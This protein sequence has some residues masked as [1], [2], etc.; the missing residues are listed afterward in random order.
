[1]KLFA[2][3]PR[4]LVILVVSLLPAIATLLLTRF[5]LHANLTNFAPVYWNDQTWYWHQT[6]SFS[7]VGFAS[8]YYMVN[9]A[10]APLTFFKF[11]SAGPLFPV[12]FGTIGH[13]IGWG[14]LSGIGLNM[15][16]LAVALWLLVYLAE[17]DKTQILLTGLALLV[18]GPVLMFLPTNSQESFHQAGA[19]ILAGLFYRLWMG[20]MSR[21]LWWIGLIFLLFISL[22]RFSWV[23]LLPAYLLINNRYPS[24]RRGIFSLLIGGLL[25]LGI[26][27]LVSF[28]SSPGHNAIV[29][30]VGAF[31]SNPVSALQ[32]L[33]YVVMD[34][35]N[36][37]F[38]GAFDLQKL[39]VNTTQ[40]FQIAIIGISAL[41]MVFPATEMRAR[42]STKPLEM[43]FHIYNLVLIIG[44]SLV[45][46]LADGFYR[47]FGLHVLV[48]LLLL[49]SFR[50]FIVSAAVIV[51]SIV[52]ISPFA[53]R[54]K[55]TILPNLIQDMTAIETTRQQWASLMPYEPDV[56]AWC[57]TLLIPRN[58]LDSRILYVPAG[59]GISFYSTGYPIPS[60]N[61]H[62]HSHYLLLDD[63]AFQ[64]LSAGYFHVEQ[65]ADT[66]HGTLYRNLDA[67][68]GSS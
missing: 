12:I 13:F 50:R 7:Q 54:Y 11:S 56:D 21:R 30:R 9:E 15:L 38:I 46:Y 68:C 33:L 44:L 4:W 2:S 63:K 23:I 47:L 60:T 40:G 49:I 26:Y 67:P 57:N 39:N 32:S 14:W 24:V 53:T 10:T 48:S 36:T 65:L 3:I 25:A 51:I 28:T 34:N 22:I 17:L 16:M 20:K 59:I 43:S 1:M 31:G 37:S 18:I 66:E 27:L 8:G 45:M 55:E 19:M 62:I 5:Y 52:M 29:G 64:Y 35:L 41:A 6:Y 42:L 58:F 61:Q